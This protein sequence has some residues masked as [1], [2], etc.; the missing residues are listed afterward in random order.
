MTQFQ[1]KAK[2][3]GVYFVSFYEGETR[4]RISTRTSDLKTARIRA[5]EIV[6]G[7][8][9]PAA[10]KARAETGS[11]TMEMLLNHC[12]HTVWS[13]R[14]VRSQATVR[15]NVR[16]LSRMIGDWRVSEITYSKLEGLVADLHAHGY[17]SGTV[18]RKMCAVSK[19]LNEATR[20]TY[21]DGRPVLAS[22]LPMPSVTTRNARDRVISSQEE[23]AIFA[24]IAVREANEPARNWRRFGHLIRFLLDTGC[25][26]GEALYVDDSRIQVRNGQHFVAFPRYTTKS[27]R[28]RTLPLSQAIVATLPYLRLA[29]P[30]G[31]L[32]P[33]KSQTAWYMFNSIRSDLK[34]AG[35][36]IDDVVLHTFRH[37]CLTRLASSGRVRLEHISDW[38]GHASM[39]V[40]RNHYVHLMPEDKLN[41]LAALESMANAIQVPQPTMCEIA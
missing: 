38:A 41:V 27:G 24:A 20:M 26:L 8:A 13:P 3:N 33:L 4:R 9:V 21:P 29:S 17:A 11:M 35:T 39:D 6:N 14:H 36:N 16:I 25:R 18:H 22:K 30:T 12:C 28:P 34:A 7:G 31:A 1:I 15:S 19:A 37:T 10:P 40:T 2:P 23:A 5:R 32:F